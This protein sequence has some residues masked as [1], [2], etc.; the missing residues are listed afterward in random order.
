MIVQ[1]NAP[2]FIRVWRWCGC[3]AM[4]FRLRAGVAAQPCAFR[5]LAPGP[6]TMLRLERKKKQHRKDY[7]TRRTNA[8]GSCIITLYSVH[9]Y[10]GLG[11]HAAV[12]AAPAYQAI[13]CGLSS[14]RSC[15]ELWRWP[16]RGRGPRAWGLFQTVPRSAPKCGSVLG[17]L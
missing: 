5:W 11:S 17:S 14:V 15:P 6:R 12:S 13:G 16:A 10:L 7:L 1:S 9:V 3:R 2:S 4:C 8:T